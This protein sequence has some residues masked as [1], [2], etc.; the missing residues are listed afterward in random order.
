MMCRVL[1]LR[2]PVAGY[3]TQPPFPTGPDGTVQY[4]GDQT[5]MMVSIGDQRSL[6]INR[7]GSAVFV[8]VMRTDAQGQAV[9]VGF[10]QAL[11]DLTASVNGSNQA[12]MQRGIGEMETLL[13]GVLLGRADVGTDLAVADQQTSVLDDITL[14][15]KSTLSDVEDLDFAAAVTKMNKQMLSLEAAQ[16]SF[17]KIAKLNLFNYIN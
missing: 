4:Q 15:L 8:P 1:T 5:R 13:Q 2:T 17:A 10:F 16:A 9:G 6:P 11:D 14:N 12:G 3:V 7:S